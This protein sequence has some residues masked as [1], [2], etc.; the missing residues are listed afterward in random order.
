[1][2]VAHLIHCFPNFCPVKLTCIHHH[3]HHHHH[4]H[5]QPTVDQTTNGSDSTTDTSVSSVLSP[6]TSYCSAISVAVYKELQTLTHH[7]H[8][9]HHH[10]HNHH[11]NEHHLIIISPWSFATSTPTSG[12]PHI[13]TL[14]PDALQTACDGFIV[15]AAVAN[16]F[17]E[18]QP[19]MVV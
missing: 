6:S 16:A 10:H 17:N 13:D 7:H 8:H 5:H 14:T 12:F 11:H 4:R 2:F 19:M 15:G 1:M 9:H 3:D 18:V